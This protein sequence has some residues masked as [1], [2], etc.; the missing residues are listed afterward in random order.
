MNGLSIG[1]LWLE[2][3][4][5]KL[6]TIIFISMVFETEDLIML[7]WKW[8]KYQNHKSYIRI[9]KQR[10]IDKSKLLGFEYFY[11]WLALCTCQI[12]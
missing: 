5:L 9:C 11:M 6:E 3:M 10:N 7:Y 12:L 1:S 4:C 8:S 2:E